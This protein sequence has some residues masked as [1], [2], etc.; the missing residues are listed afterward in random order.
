[1]TLRRKLIAEC[2]FLYH[3]NEVIEYHIEKYFS[4]LEKYN[5][6]WLAC[7]IDERIELSRGKSEHKMERSYLHNHIQKKAISIE[8]DHAALKSLNQERE[9]YS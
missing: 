9:V 4:E 8:I 6:L 2:D 5:F 1:M 7:H 3:S